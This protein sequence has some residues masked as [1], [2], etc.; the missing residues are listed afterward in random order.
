MGPSLETGALLH[1]SIRSSL[2]RGVDGKS[3][4]VHT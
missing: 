3:V 1:S 4:M 2:S